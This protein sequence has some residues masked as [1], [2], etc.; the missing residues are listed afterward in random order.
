VTERQ[1]D[2]RRALVTGASSGIGAAIARALAQR[3]ANLVLVARRRDRLDALAEKLREFDVDVLVEVM[4]LSDS[5][6]AARLLRRTEGNDLAIDI[7]VNNA[8]LGHYETFVASDWSII[9]QQLRVN[10]VALT[11][12]THR[13]LPAMIARGHGHVMNVA[14]V[15]AYAPTPNF[16]VYTATKAYVR[17]LS[18][19][20]DFELAGTG[21]RTICV[22]PGGT[23][24]EFTDHANQVVKPTGERLMMSAERCAEIAVEKM[25]AGRRSVVTGWTNALGMWALR[26]LP[27]ATYPWLAGMTMSQAVDKGDAGKR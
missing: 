13:F 11:E 16:A 23:K 22:N 1:I 4:D 17:H 8:G 19:A 27:R 12:L 14:S 26:L 10:L 18:E 25:L 3:G 2:G 20:L 24:T 7:L 9:E 21:V 15:G 6:A 5:G